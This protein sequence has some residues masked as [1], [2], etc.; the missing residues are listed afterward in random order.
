MQN[1]FDQC[2]V[3]LL[4]H[5]GGFVNDPRDPGGMTNLGVTRKVYEAFVGHD[6]DEAIM[7]ALTPDLVSPLYRANYWAKIGGDDLPAGVDHAAMDFAVNS[8]VGRAAKFLQRVVGVKDD[9]AVGLGT[10]QA[11]RRMDAEIVITDLCNARLAF[12][13]GLSTFDRF[14]TGWTRRINEVETQAKAMMA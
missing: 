9:G 3:Y 12:L 14:G 11:V 7:R 1:N 2:L 5:E 8:G 10:L 4:K 6:V 13:Q